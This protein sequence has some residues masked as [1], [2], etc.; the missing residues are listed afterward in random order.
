MSFPGHY[1]V[2]REVDNIGIRDI[3]ANAYVNSYKYIVLM[4]DE[5]D[6]K[7]WPTPDD[8]SSSELTAFNTAKGN[9]QTALG[10]CFAELK[11][12]IGM[13]GSE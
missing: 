2:P 12:I 6:A 5:L 10:T 3:S 7:S 1:Q 9:L 8:I 13:L 4:K 11:T